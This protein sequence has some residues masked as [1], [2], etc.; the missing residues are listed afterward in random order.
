[1]H[2]EVEE[3]DIAQSAARTEAAANALATIEPQNVAATVALAMPGS[4]TAS[5]AAHT[6][7]AVADAARAIAADLAAHAE[8]LRLAV[9]CYAD[10]EDRVLA[11][12]RRAAGVA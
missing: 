4:R 7:A 2:V 9:A 8:A 12:G 5:E 6:A 3:S 10:T 11:E 1:M